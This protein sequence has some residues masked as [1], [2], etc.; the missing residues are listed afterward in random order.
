MSTKLKAIHFTDLNSYKVT[1]EGNNYKATYF[2]GDKK[3]TKWPTFV[4]DLTK[5]SVSFT[6]EVISYTNT[7][8]G[9]SI[10]RER[11]VEIKQDLVDKYAA[12]T[13]ECGYPTFDSLDNEYAYRK[14]IDPYS[15]SSETVVSEPEPVPVEVEA[16]SVSTGNPFIESP[17]F[18]DSAI[19]HGNLVY[20]YK[21][22]EAIRTVITEEFKKLGFTYK[23]DISYSATANKRIWGC[24]SDIKYCTAFG[25]YIFKTLLGT[26]R[27]STVSTGSLED[28]R[29]AYEH[30]KKLISSNLMTLYKATFGEFDTEAINR[31][32][33]DTFNL[34]NSAQK[35][36]R[37]ATGKRKSDREAVQEVRSTLNTLSSKLT[38]FLNSDN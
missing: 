6:T 28:M 2:Y 13:D 1:K 23:G 4:T 25:H 21:R 19:K 10:T 37:F 29:A 9:E 15:S 31:L 7:E 8:T 3:V 16:Y 14:A 26:D 30:D 34:V 27:I 32:I 33:V 24:G 18:I 12:D 35:R 5:F 20:T 17:L 22:M 36:I 38:S 11:F